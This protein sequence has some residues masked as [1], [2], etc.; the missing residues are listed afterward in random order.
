MGRGVASFGK[1]RVADAHLVERT[2]SG[3]LSEWHR[4]AHTGER[5]TGDGSSQA[6]WRARPLVTQL[7]DRTPHPRVHSQPNHLHPLSPPVTLAAAFLGLLLV[8]SEIGEFRH[9]AIEQTVSEEREREKDGHTPP[10]PPP[11]SL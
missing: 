10:Q 8:T 11:P 7:P 1:A 9:P 3:A 5:E 2:T 6:P 4:V